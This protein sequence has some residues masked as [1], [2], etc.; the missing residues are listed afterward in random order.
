MAQD[1][2]DIHHGSWEGAFFHQKVSIFFLFLDENMCCGYSLEVPRRGTSNEY[3]NV[4]FHQ[5]IRK[6]FTWYPFLSRPMI[7]TWIFFLFL[8][9]NI[10]CGYSLEAPQQGA[11]NIMFSLR[12]MKI[13]SS[14]ADE[15]Y[16]LVKNYANN[17]ISLKAE[18]KLMA[19][20]TQKHK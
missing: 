17:Q 20:S 12:N 4:C 16:C 9:E 11:N 7:H 15:K 13:I 1:K 14:F 19:S 5:E 8:L 18:Q 6:L 10:C 2:R 3:H